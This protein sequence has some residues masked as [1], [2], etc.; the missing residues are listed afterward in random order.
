MEPEVSKFLT[1]LMQCISMLLFWMLLNTFFGIKMGY[2]FLEKPLT[3]WHAVYYV[4]MVASF[5]WVLRYILKKWRQ[6][7]RFGG[8]DQN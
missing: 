1:L 7:P 4:G 3:V 8:P 5:V 2:L 6:M